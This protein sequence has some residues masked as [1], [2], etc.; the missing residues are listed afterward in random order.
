MTTINLNPDD[1]V[2]DSEL[3]A[4]QASENFH[5]LLGRLEHLF[6][7][8]FMA[9]VLLN[10]VSAAS[11]YLGGRPLLGAD[12]IQVYTMVWLIFMGAAVVALRRMHLRMDVLT[13]GLGERQ[14]RWRDGIESLLMALTCA[15]MTWVSAEF[16]WQIYG[17]EQRSDA[18]SIPMWIPHLSAALGFGV[19]TLGSAYSLIFFL[20]RPAR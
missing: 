13:A 5:R 4:R 10:F 20:L 2:S 8:V 17:M 18:A 6:G 14:A 15:T 3:R 19:M 9:V 16:T 12:E 1:I 7:L 11:R